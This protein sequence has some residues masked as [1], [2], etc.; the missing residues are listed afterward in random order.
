MKRIC[1]VL[2]CL[3][4]VSTTLA[5]SPSVA[6]T[7]DDLP[8]AGTSDT[9]EIRAINL[10][11]LNSLDRHHAPATAFVIGQNAHL[12]SE[13]WPMLEEWKHRGYTLGNHTWSHPNF[14]DLTIV[15][16]ED[17]ILK[18]ERAIA[19]LLAPGIK[20]LRFPYNGTGDTSEKHDA[21]LSFL[22]A[23]H[24]QIATCTI[25]NEDYVFAAVYNKML[26]RHDADAAARL[27][28]AYLDYTATEI[29]Y[30]THLHKQ[31][32]GREIPHVMLLH[33]S[34]LN[35]D[36]INQVLALFTVRGYQF[37]TLTQAQSDPGY[38]TPD[39][40]ATKYGPMWG[41][42]WAKE[43]GISLKNNHETEP[44]TWISEYG[45]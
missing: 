5:Q 29:D 31:I 9:T 38:A 8:A 14:A 45:K 26:A 2:F 18:G 15:Q 10:A 34:R 22:K 11:I 43:L 4:C 6:L 44:P 25:D 13:S 12:T 40:Y 21:I 28:A 17:D 24:Y 23:H 3:L 32:F 41:Y 33:A 16:E 36:M 1:F 37:V 39:T 35:A 30:Y 7:F 42:R 27:R 19:P 20:F